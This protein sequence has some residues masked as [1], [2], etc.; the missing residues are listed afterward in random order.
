VTFM[1]FDM[2]SVL[3][4][5]KNICNFISNSNDDEEC[6]EAGTYYLS[7]SFQMPSEIE[8]FSYII[9]LLGVSLYAYD[10]SE[11]KIGCWKASLNLSKNNYS[12]SLKASIAFTGLGALVFA[13]LFSMK[14]RKVAVINI[15]NNS[16]LM[17][18]DHNSH[19]CAVRV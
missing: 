5:T 6:P 10:D 7:N 12:S 2:F 16:E 19:H 18:N 4:Q 8:N 15:E 17:D 11:N 13:F 14:R 3:N 1:G 9:N